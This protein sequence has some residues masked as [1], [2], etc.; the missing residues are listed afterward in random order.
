MA[1]VA[2]E[3]AVDGEAVSTAGYGVTDSVGGAG[4]GATMISVLNVSS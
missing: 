3:E 4:D 1:E 2:S